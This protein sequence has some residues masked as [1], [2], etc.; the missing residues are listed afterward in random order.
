MANEMQDQTTAAADNIFR[1]AHAEAVKVFESL[2]NL[3]SEVERAA[4]LCLESLKSGHKLVMC[5]NGGSAAQAQHLV[6]ELMGR[7]NSKRRS[8]SA[9]ALNADSATLTCIANDY[10]YED[11]FAR[12]IEG[13]CRPGDVLIVFSTSG[14]SPNIIRALEA[15][16]SLSIRSIGFFG[17]QGGKAGKLADISL[18]VGHKATTRI[19]EGHQFLLHALMDAMERELTH[20]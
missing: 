15:A 4:A 20:V 16:R 2:R 5:G 19:Q 12:Q 7:Y 17:N 8:W 9:V 14:N 10:S 11:V 1:A 6:G 13:L 18:I 3:E